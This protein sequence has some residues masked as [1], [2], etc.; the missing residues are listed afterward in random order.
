MVD[1]IF[2]KWRFLQS[3]AFL[4]ICS[5]SCQNKLRWG[6]GN[7][8]TAT[9]QLRRRKIHLNTPPPSRFRRLW[10]AFIF[11]NFHLSFLNGVSYYLLRFEDPTVCK[12][13]A[14]GRQGGS[15]EFDSLLRLRGY[16]K[17]ASQS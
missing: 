5:F 15:P 3:K 13:Q 4:R 2:I 6:G 10:N 8:I 12:N 16:Q 17:L 9:P 7:W 1:Q 11:S 14:A